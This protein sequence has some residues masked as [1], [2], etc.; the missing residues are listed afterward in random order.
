MSG[1]LFI[2]PIDAPPQRNARIFLSIPSQREEKKIM[3]SP[4]SQVPIWLASMLSTSGRRWAG[5]LLL[6]FMVAPMWGAQ[7]VEIVPS[8]VDGVAMEGP[9]SAG[10]HA[11]FLVSIAPTGV[12]PAALKEVSLV[13]SYSVRISNNSSRNIAQ[14][15]VRYDFL[16]KDGQPIHWRYGRGYPAGHRFLPGSTDIMRG[17]APNQLASFAASPYLRTSVDAVVFEDGE[18]AGPDVGGLF[19]KE[20]AHE[21]ENRSLIAE[22]NDLG[23]GPKDQVLARIDAMRNGE[24]PLHQADAVKLK[25]YFSNTFDQ[26]RSYLRLLSELLVEPVLWRRQ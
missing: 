7:G 21:Q 6:A 19:A 13:E 23:L 8:L 2:I 10:F 9:D 4:I 5:A 16:G 1:L 11:Q 24:A 12:A 18:V 15:F 14:V 25:G 17:V 26:G 20:K 22:L 3:F